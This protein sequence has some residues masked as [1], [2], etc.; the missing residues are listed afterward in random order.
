M[1]PPLVLLHGALG[2][3]S[4]WQAIRPLLEN[5]FDVFVPDFPG[6]GNSTLAAPS[7]IDQLVDFLSEYLIENQLHSPYI[8]GYSM[9]GYVAL[10]AAS[11]YNIQC[12][13]LVCLATKMHWST[14]IAAVETAKLTIQ[15]LS[16]ILPKLQAEHGRNFDTLLGATVSVINSIGNAP[17]R[18]SDMANVL[19]TFTFI[20]GDKDKMVSANEHEQFILSH[21]NAHYIEM[22]GQ[23]HLLERMEAAP[24]AK[25]FKQVFQ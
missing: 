2:S 20:R 6:H 18:T 14:D 19:N 10:M 8:A 17:I 3:A 4:H 13:G 7:H 22:P 9:G 23:G 24:V 11:R 12:S 21:T 25:L 1:K 16:P 15:D 5:D